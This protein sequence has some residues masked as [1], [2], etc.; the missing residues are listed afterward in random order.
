MLEVRRYSVFVVAMIVALVSAMSSAEA[1]RRQVSFCNKNSF[2][3]DVAWGYDL[4]GTDETRSEGWKTVHSCRCEV[5]FDQDVKATEFFF[6]AR[7]PKT[8][9]TAS[10][11][12]GNAP[13]CIQS[14]AFTIRK[15][16]AGKA[17]CKKLGGEWVNF[18]QGNAEK[19][20]WAVNFRVAGSSSVCQD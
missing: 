10:V 9:L 6:Y 4:S 20:I 15:S 14:K 3:L 2:T 18:R 1:V 19:E 8:P 7:K 13:L 11:S 16:N 17:E 12:G 5:L